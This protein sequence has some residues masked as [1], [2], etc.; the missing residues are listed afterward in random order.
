MRKFLT[1]LSLVAGLF[2][3]NAFAQKAEEP[4]DCILK[5]LQGAAKENAFVVRL[6]CIRKYLRAVEGKASIVPLNLT[7]Q[8]TAYW[9]PRMSTLGYPYYTESQL[10]VDIKNNSLS[11]LIFAVIHI[12][13]KETQ[14]IETYK[15]YADAPI[16]PFSVGSFTGAIKVSEKIIT[17][18]EFWDKHIWTIQSVNGI[19][20]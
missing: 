15:I 1:L 19:T 6:N 3:Y 10:R 13:N 5:A 8:A 4:E 17:A 2:S 18:A 20:K 12:T 11:R 16:D 14:E 7:S 9:T